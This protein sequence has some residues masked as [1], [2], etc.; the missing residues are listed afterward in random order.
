VVQITPLI[1]TVQTFTVKDSATIT[2]SGGG[3]LA[4][5]VRFRLYNNLTCAGTPLHDS[6]AIAV[7]GASPQTRETSVITLS[8]PANAT[9]A[10]TLAWLVEYTSTNP[11]Q[12][13]VTSACNTERATLNVVNQ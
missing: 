13:G 11:A 2:A 3:N 6:G 9:T 4:G 5:S 7:S 1:S 12:S 8:T 10:L